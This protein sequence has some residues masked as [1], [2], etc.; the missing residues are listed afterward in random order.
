[1]ASTYLGGTHTETG[2]SITL[3]RSGN[4][5]VAGLTYSS[6]FPTTSGAYDTSWNSWN[7]DS[8]VF[9]SKLDGGLTSLLAS[10]YLGGSSSDVG[11][12]LALDTS[13]NVYVAGFTGSTDFPTTSGA[14]DTS[15]NGV[16]DVF[17]S[18]LDGGLT[19]LLAS[20]YLGGSS[21]DGGFSL[22][23]DTSG[24]IYV[25]GLAVSPDFP[26]TGG[27]YDTS[28]NGGYDAFVSK[29]NNGLTSLLASTFL[30]GSGRNHG[31]SITL[32]TSGNVYVAGFTGSTDFPTTSGAYDTSW[33]G[34][35]DVFISK[36]DG[37]LTSLLASTYLGG[38]IMILVMLLPST[39]AGM[40]M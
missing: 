4:V 24:N 14:Y 32:D 7:S 11:L 10:T 29:L 31:A 28:F 6:D 40:Y 30:G 21:S 33:N 26:T 36:L 27:A 12:S 17:V 35:D 22:A 3:D 8:D 2:Y 20:T 25:T 34:V 18:K 9:I 15:W 16:D 5:Y 1:M 39:Q 13:G 19:N 23:L 37:G 38:S